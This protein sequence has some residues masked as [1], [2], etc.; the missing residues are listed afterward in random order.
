VGDSRFFQGQVLH[1]FALAL[2][3]A[4]AAASTALPGFSEGELFG[5][6][7]RAWFWLAVWEAVAHQVYAWFCWRLELGSQAL[8][9]TFGPR[10][11][12]LYQVGFSVLIVARPLLV[13]ALA[14]S[15]ADTL[16][17]DPV[18]ARTLTVLALIPSAYLGY[19]VARYFGFAR[20]Y[21][22]DHFDPSYRSQPIV[23]RGIFRFS[24]NA[25]YVFGFL[26]LWA[27]GLWF[28]SVAALVCAAF[29]HAYIWVHY[30]GTE[31]P[32]MRVIYGRR[33]GS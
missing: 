18:L 27:P 5:L 23:R 10:G 3:I 20:A 33:A 9:R 31:L 30:W 15:N 19:S 28:G 22:A 13:L 7:T 21:G 14:V 26:L 32:D 1:L 25:M 16:A 24:S 11:F 12:V 4:A 2:L 8:T 29:G 17:L 6:S